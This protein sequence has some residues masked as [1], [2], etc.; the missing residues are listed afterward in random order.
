MSHRRRN[1]LL[2][3]DEVEWLLQRYSPDMMWVADDVFTI[4][5]GWIRNYAAEM[6]RRGLRVP[7]GDVFP[8][9]TV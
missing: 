6:R 2:V 4:H 3:V 7:F 5:H 1:P 8:A 9:P